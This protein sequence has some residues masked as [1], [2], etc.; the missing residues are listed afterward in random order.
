MHLTSCQEAF[1][2]SSHSPRGNLPELSSYP[3]PFGPWA[4]VHPRVST[5]FSALLRYSSV[6]DVREREPVVPG[7]CAAQGPQNW[8]FC[9]AQR[10][11]MPG[12]WSPTPAVPWGPQRLLFFPLPERDTLASHSLMTACWMVPWGCCAVRLSASCLAQQPNP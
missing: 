1:L 7:L 8:L 11:V 2:C 12:C 10:S 4:R 3:F 5:L 9:C 6:W